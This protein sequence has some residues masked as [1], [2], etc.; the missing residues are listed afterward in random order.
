MACHRANRSHVARRG[1]GSTSGVALPAVVLCLTALA[2]L[3]TGLLLTA[4]TEQA[5]SR[6][7]RE[8]IED[9]YLAESAIH[10]WIARE[11]ADLQ[12]GVF[13]PWTPPGAPGASRIVVDRL[14]DAGAGE[15][16]A[17]Y[18]IAAEPARG[19]SSRGVAALVRVRPYVPAPFEPDLR[20]TIV[21]G[22]AA[23]VV[24]SASSGSTVMS[25]AASGCTAADA[26]LTRAV[27]TTLHAT[28]ADVFEGSPEQSQL[29]PEP[30]V[31]A[32]LGG[33][34]IRDLGWNADVRFGRHFNEPPYRSVMEADAAPGTRYDWG[35]PAH[36]LS[37]LPA[38]S[39]DP[40]PTGTHAD[41]WRIVA[42]DAANDT[43]RLERGHGQG[44]LVV[45]GGPLVIDGS[46]VFRGLIL[47]EG[48]VRIGGGVTGWPASV[49]G[50]IVAAGGVSVLDGRDPSSGAATSRRRILDY[51][52]CAVDRAAKAFNAAGGGRWS[53]PAVLGRPY[54][55]VGVIR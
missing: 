50:A 42:I 3:L 38:E 49:T 12:P 11:G 53:A 37:S 20:S 52:A 46:F 1:T 47:A 31:S 23:A 43:V 29:A 6:A 19:V 8:A 55:W 17:I 32:V 48:A 16:H 14:A 24:R 18:S 27:G 22:G 41:R 36:L 34:R 2:L 21:S 26:P 7:Y 40:C 51:D 35:C 28:A 45:V 13:G 30:L 10:A 5:V 4:A 44:V 33:H 54:G 15:G 9:A 39:V 25:G